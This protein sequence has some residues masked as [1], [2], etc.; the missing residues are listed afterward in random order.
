[1]LKINIIA[2]FCIGILTT[3]S[4]TAQSDFVNFETPQVHPLDINFDKTLLVA[5]NTADNR[6]EVYNLESGTPVHI[7]AV[8]VGLDPVS[9]RFRT[10]TE[11][12][13]VNQISDSISIVELATM[14]L[15]DTFETLDEP[16][17]V[18]FSIGR[19]FISCA[20]VDIVQVYSAVTLVHLADIPIDGEEPRALAV[21]PDQNTV[22]CAIFESGNRSTVINGSR[23]LDETNTVS[24]PAGPYM[25][26][27]PPPNNGNAIDP[28]L[29]VANPPLVSHIVKKDDSD[30]WMDDNNGNW[31]DFVSGANAD[32]SNRIPGWDLLDNDVALIDVTDLVVT[33]YIEGLM[34]ICMAIATN[35]ITG[36][37]TVVGVDGI[38]E[39]RFEPNINGIFIRVILG[40]ATPG[41]LGSPD[42]I[43]L[44]SEPG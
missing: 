39:Q 5:C 1:M 11:V 38:N 32:R 30:Q 34:N 42:V 22:Y 9:V 4:A 23:S 16:A 29:A 43:D 35:P 25:G 41:T 12:W 15:I 19:A 27:N 18:V 36:D 20:S 44:N 17:D 24:D 40:L 28:P 2:V 21:S 37:V 10:N 3:L 6:I 7:G 13:V 33:G 26:V 14:T 31:T 8:P